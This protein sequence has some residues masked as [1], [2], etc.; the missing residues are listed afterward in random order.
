MRAA[1]IGCRNQP[2]KCVTATG[3]EVAVKALQ[4]RQAA[5]ENDHLRI[6]QV[7]D[8]GQRAPEAPFVTL[9]RRF[10]GGIAGAGAFVDGRRGEIL[11]G[12][13]RVVASQCRAGKVGFDAA[14]AP[15]IAGGKRQVGGARERQGVVPPFAGDGVGASH[16][17]P[18]HDDA[19]TDAGAE[20]DPE[21]NFG[22]PA[23]AVGRLGEG[24]AVGIVG[25]ADLAL[26]QRFQIVAQRPADQAGRIGVL[27]RATGPCFGARN[28][29][30]ERSVLPQFG[31][32]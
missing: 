28:A 22:A 12:M 13:A 27:D 25:E 6:E 24:K 21:D 2:K 30:A 10:A 31:F 15:A 9:Q 7:D 11:A 32:R 14:A 19:A 18:V 20:N 26:E 23:G 16:Q 29:D 8:T 5:A 17:L 4:V 3:G 1:Q